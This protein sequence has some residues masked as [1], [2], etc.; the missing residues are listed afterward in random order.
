MYI[1]LHYIIGRE[2]RYQHTCKCVL[3]V[4]GGGGGKEGEVLG[5]VS[6][7]NS[8]CQNLKI[9]LIFIIIS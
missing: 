9:A 8:I 1:S 5:S 7:N 6:Y 2:I 4:L 3:G